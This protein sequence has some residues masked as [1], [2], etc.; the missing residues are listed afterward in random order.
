MLEQLKEDVCRANLQ[1]PEY[2]LVTFT[3][4]NVS[5]I[6]REK[7]L[8]VI[9][10]SG[11]SYE[12]LK[13]EHMVVIDLGLNHVQGA[14]K[15]RCILL[16]MLFGKLGMMT[17]PLLITAGLGRGAAG[18]SGVI[19]MLLFSGLAVYVLSGLCFSF[20]KKQQH[21]WRKR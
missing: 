9:K 2:E 1:L 21:P 17:G 12:E 20:Q 6:D 15:E 18:A 13:P 3:W 4:G 5:G 8:F 14:S 19:V 7:G 11:V 16:Q 10:P